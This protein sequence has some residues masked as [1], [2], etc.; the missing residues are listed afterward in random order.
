[1][2]RIAKTFLIILTTL[3]ITNPFVTYA[4]SGLDSQYKDSS[5]PLE[6]IFSLGS[7]GLS[8]VA[9]LINAEPNKEGY[10]SR[11]ITLAILCTIILLI[12]SWIAIYKLINSK[13]KKS[14]RVLYSL[15][16]SLIPTILFFLLCI[17]T[18][19]QLVLYIFILIIY[20]VPFSLI[21]KKITKKILKKKIKK[22]KELDKKFN[23]EEFGREAFR[24]YNEVQLAWMDFKLTKVKDLLDKKLYDKYK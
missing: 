17:L 2:K 15:L 4:D 10:E 8:F 6:A 9:E 18:K 7:S 22:A 5:S 14:K 12:V 11:H 3:I 24:I 20:I 13:H 16:Y 21:T 1:M 19:L 23:E